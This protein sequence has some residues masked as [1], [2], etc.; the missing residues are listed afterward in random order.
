MYYYLG[1][2][3]LEMLTDGTAYC[4]CFYDLR[5]STNNGENF[6]HGVIPTASNIDLL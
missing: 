5:P 4:G 2:V 3:I 1:K 6:N